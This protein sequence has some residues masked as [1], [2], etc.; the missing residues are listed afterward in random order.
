MPSEDGPEV[1]RHLFADLIT[2]SGEVCQPIAHCVD[3]L[4]RGD[5]V[6]VQ[7]ELDLVIDDPRLP[8]RDL[9]TVC[10]EHVSACHVDDDRRHV[11]IAQVISRY[12]R[13]H[14]NG[15]RRR[16]VRRTSTAPP[17]GRPRAERVHARRLG[18]IELATLYVIED[19]VRDLGLYTWL[20][21]SETLGGTRRVHATRGKRDEVMKV[22]MVAVTLA[23]VVL[24]AGACGDDDDSAS[25]ESNDVTI[26][27]VV[28]DTSIVPWHGEV[29][30]T[31]GAVDAGAVCAEGEGSETDFAELEADEESMT[32][33]L[34]MTVVCADGSGEFVLQDDATLDVV[35]GVP[36]EEDVAGNWTVVSGTADYAELSGNGE[37]TNE[38]LEQTT[39]TY[40]GQLSL[41]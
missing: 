3:H 26:T 34:D 1:G 32:L 33:R 12:L 27:W 10:T 21:G 23:G 41:G 24:M 6:T 38:G 5:V 31:G 25:S 22:R 40:T 4:R 8:T 17:T 2:G 19:G 28:A 36:V 7:E 11:Q 29:T 16:G 14:R 30:L 39:K 35:D 15:Q 13:F 18:A 9:A 37:S 20:G